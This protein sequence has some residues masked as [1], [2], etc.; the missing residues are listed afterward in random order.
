MFIKY[1]NKH[2]YKPISPYLLNDLSDTFSVLALNGDNFSTN[3]YA[4][5]ALAGLV[6]APSYVFPLFV[7]MF[8]GRKATSALLFL[9]SGIALLCILFISQGN[10]CIHAVINE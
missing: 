8:L 4:Y 2:V 1:L 7:L 5:L 10:F 9:T 3:R 6:E